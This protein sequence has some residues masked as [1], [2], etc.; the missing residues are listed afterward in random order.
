[1]RCLFPVF[2]LRRSFVGLNS[3]WVQKDAL[4]KS[5]RKERLLSISSSWAREEREFPAY[6]A[7]FEHL[8]VDPEQMPLL[9]KEE[10]Q[11]VH[12]IGLLYQLP[13]PTC[14]DGFLHELHEVMRQLDCTLPILNIQALFIQHMYELQ[15]D[16]PCNVRWEYAPA[17]CYKADES[18]DESKK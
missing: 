7:K 17:L 3:I 4:S 10:I 1:M 11:K 2:N 14:Q 13:P 12:Q 16:L 18:A 6:I 5:E 8:A 15:F 9:G